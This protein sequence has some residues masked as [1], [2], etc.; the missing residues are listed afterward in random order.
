MRLAIKKYSCAPIRLVYYGRMEKPKHTHP[1]FIWAK[2]NG[3]KLG[4]LADQ[5]G[6]RASTVSEYLSGK[7]SPNTATRLAFELVT[8]GGVKADQWGAQ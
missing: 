8:G 7:S 5:V 1:L 6:I 4:F 3:V 2:A